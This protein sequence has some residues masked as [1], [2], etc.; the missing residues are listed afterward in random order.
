VGRLWRALGL[1]HTFT[2]D[3]ITP[4]S[5]GGTN[6]LQ[7]LVGA[8]PECNAAKADAIPL[9][10]A[11]GCVGVINA[12]GFAQQ[13]STLPMCDA[14]PLYRREEAAHGRSAL[15]SPGQASRDR[16]AT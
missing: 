15:R 12:G 6:A 5:A 10:A 2:I 7:N 11:V 1:F 13:A 14:A 3:H 9:P 4:R 16:F 8:C